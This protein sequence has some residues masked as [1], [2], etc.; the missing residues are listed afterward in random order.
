M[1]AYLFYLIVPALSLV[2]CSNQSGLT[3]EEAN[4]A[5]TADS[6]GF[7]KDMTA[8]NSPSRKRVRTADVRCRVKNVYQ[9]ATALERAVNAMNGIIVTST[10]ENSFGRQQ[11]VPYAGDSLK[12]V[13][14]YTPTAALTLRVPAAGLDSV[15]RTLTAMASF[16][17]YR[18]LKEED[19][20]LTYLSNAL[21]NEREPEAVFTGKQLDTSL[22][23][24]RYNDA[25]AEAA[26]DRKIANL[27]ILDDVNYA[28]FTVQLLQPEMADVQIVVNPD[29]VIRAGFGTELATA[30][31]NGMDI[32]RNV[33]LFFLQLWPFLLL[34]AAAW[35]GYRKMKFTR[36]A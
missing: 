5:A 16:I 35:W 30:L 36:T 15:V 13:Q 18:T 33:V 26:I 3:T 7:S 12:R 32:C 14:L 2:A 20:T 22:A 10:L 24:A 21:R 6:T 28:T 34:L 27:A 1:R 11:D 4:Y 19:K 25:H 31:R 9:A 17:D 23:E 8:L 29:R